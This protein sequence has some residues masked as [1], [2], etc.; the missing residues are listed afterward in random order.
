MSKLDEYIQELE[1]IKYEVCD[2]LCKYPE[3]YTPD[4]WDEV[5]CEICDDC[6]LNKL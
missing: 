4:E 3:Q 1:K 6:P 5:M 2:K